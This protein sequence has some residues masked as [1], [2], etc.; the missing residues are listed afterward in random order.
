MIQS[1]CLSKVTIVLKLVASLQRSFAVSGCLTM[2]LSSRQA[3]SRQRFETFLRSLDSAR[4]SK[5]LVTF[6]GAVACYENAR[7]ATQE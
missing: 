7:L 3:A 4:V 1:V 6:R 2:S 5:N